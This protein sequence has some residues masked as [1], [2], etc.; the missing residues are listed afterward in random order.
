MQTLGF[1]QKK[2]NDEKRLK[3]MQSGEVLIEMI[4]LRAVTDPASQLFIADRAIPLT[5]QLGFSAWPPLWRHISLAT[6]DIDAFGLDVV[7]QTT[8]RLC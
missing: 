1:Q 7:P 2:W 4:D 5:G 6:Y 3:E 8:K